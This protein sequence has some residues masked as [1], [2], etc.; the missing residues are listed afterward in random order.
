MSLEVALEDTIIALIAH[1][2]A[3]AAFQILFRDLGLC[4]TRDALSLDLVH[5]FSLHSMSSGAH[6]EGTKEAASDAHFPCSGHLNYIKQ[7]WVN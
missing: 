5:Y 6:L 1:T 2:G 3:A 7:S 4:V